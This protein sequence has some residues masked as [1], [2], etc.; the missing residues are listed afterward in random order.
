VIA[1]HPSARL[2]IDLLDGCDVAMGV[3]RPVSVLLLDRSEHV[4][5]ATAKRATRRSACERSMLPASRISVRAP[6]WKQ[7]IAKVLL[8]SRVSSIHAFT[9][10]I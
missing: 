7:I 5:Q 10:A 2:G 8:L 3:V 4:S 1:F 9:D 6:L